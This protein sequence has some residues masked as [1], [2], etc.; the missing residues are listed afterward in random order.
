MNLS[1]KHNQYLKVGSFNNIKIYL[2]SLIYL[3]DK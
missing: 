3:F 2:L 1:D